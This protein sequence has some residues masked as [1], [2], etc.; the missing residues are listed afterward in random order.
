M[1]AVVMLFREW[2]AQPSRFEFHS[3]YLE[4]RNLQFVLRLLMASC[5]V[6]LGAVPLVMLSSP[7]GPSGVIGSAVAY[8][9]AAMTLGLAG[10]WLWEW[11]TERRSLL[12]VVAA[13][14]GI[15]VTSMVDQ[16]PLAG[17]S[18]TQAF[19]LMGF[20]VA[21][22]HTPR[23]MLVHLIWTTAVLVQIATVLALGE[24]HDVPAAAAKLLLSLVVAVTVPLGVQLLL[25][26]LSADLAASARDPLTGILNRR[27]L[28][29]AIRARFGR[30]DS[31]VGFAVLVVDVDNFKSIND[32]F[33][34]SVGDELLVDVAVSLGENCLAAEVARVGGEEF[35]IAAATAADEVP[36]LA[37]RLRANAT[38]MVGSRR[39][40][41]SVGA[42]W[43][44]DIVSG[45]TAVEAL[46]AMIREADNAMYR[47][48]TSG[49]DRV[50]VSARN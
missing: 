22:F 12:F 37:E 3:T 41:V 48:K 33:G 40:T 29:L 39:V 46:P 24:H 9:T 44:D 31:R 36:E 17:L 8:G 45:S 13:D 28:E 50:V 49:G 20:Y 35:V 1:A 26:M 2:W 30:V 25:P 19:I 43:R 11:P 27:G 6:V 5:V 32:T 18:G 34:H 47:A 38:Q 10:L 42:V 21:L 16:H 4:W 14:I 15:G 23:V 7:D